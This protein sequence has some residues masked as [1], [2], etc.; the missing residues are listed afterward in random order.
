MT[1]TTIN[2]ASPRWGLLAIVV[3][4]VSLIVLDSTVVA[5]SIP[6][7]I[8]D[9]SLTLTQAQW[10]AALYTVIF[11]ALLLTVGSLGDRVGTKALF[12]AGLV[13]FA[14]ASLLAA[15]A[16]GAALLLLARGLQGV[17]GALVLPS[18]LSTIN[19]NF[20]GAS[21]ATAFG[22]WGAVMAAMAAIGPLLGGW[23]TQTWSWEWVFLINPPIAIAVFIAGVLV[24]P[25]SETQ[26]A[27]LDLGGSLLSA[28]AMGLLVYGLIE[29]TTY[30]WLRMRHDVT[31]GPLTWR[32]GLVSPTLVAIIVGLALLVTFVVVQNRRRRAGKVV[33]LDVTLFRLPS[34]ANGNLTAMAVAVGEFGA[35]FV[36]PLFLINVQGYGAIEAGWILAA[37]AIG[38]F[39]SGAMA[40]HVAGLVGPAWTVV[41]GLVLEV[42]AIAGSVLATGISAR[43]PEA[44]GGL[45]IPAPAAESM[46]EVTV[47]SAGSALAAVA[48]QSPDTNAVHAAL[49]E[50]FT[51]ARACPCGRRRRRSQSAWRPR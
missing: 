10:V 25:R 42:A 28:L 18:T 32:E 11:A 31:F 41:I 34:F 3:V 13:V 20:R 33:L 47:N 21:R 2:P 37:L 12:L 19:A 35:L 49:V 36:L 16:N 15:L 1:R 50:S 24:L 8:S 44:L 30:G 45:G 29:A 48:E 7:I 51:S 43:L 23:I 22:L 26:S 39:F 46:T 4:G 17:G 9:L 5:V 38:A 14:L 40:R 27:P 6:A